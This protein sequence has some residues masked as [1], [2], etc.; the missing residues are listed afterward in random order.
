VALDTLSVPATSSPHHPVPLGACDAHSHIFGPFERYPPLKP[1]TYPLQEATPVVHQLM[2][3]CLGMPRGVLVQPAPY[4]NDPSAILSAIAESRGTLRGVAVADAEVHDETLLRWKDGGITGLRFVEMRSP[5]GDRYPGSVGFETLTALAPR[6]RKLGL[7]AQL[8]AP[9]EILALHLP[10]LI[11]LGVPI[12]LDHMA[13]PESARGIEDPAF[14][15]ISNLL[16]DHDLWVKLTIC[17]VSKAAPEFADVRP[18]HDA[19]IGTA[20]NK[21]LWGSDWPYVRLTPAPDAGH[22]L[23]L[24]HEWTQDAAVRRQVLVDNPRRL[25]GFKEDD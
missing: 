10:F 9:A 11:R 4:A 13:S 17:R 23:D 1:S 8:W 22:M 19:L 2:R 14:M 6:M 12:V 3:R 16:R 25:Y 20:P 21:L 5:S 7:H 18:F 24:F 15:A